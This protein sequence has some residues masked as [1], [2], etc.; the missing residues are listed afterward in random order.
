MEDPDYRKIVLTFVRRLRQK[1]V[2]MREAQDREDF[3]ELAELGHW[4]K[5][6]GATVGFEALSPPGEALE[7][8]AKSHDQAGVNRSLEEITDLASRIDLGSAGELSAVGC[9]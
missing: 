5:G 3:A 6:S 8:S 1:I 4:L 2:A 7:S 9:N